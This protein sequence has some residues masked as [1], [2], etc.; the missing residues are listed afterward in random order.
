M[1]ALFREVNPIPVKYVA[2]LQGLCAPE[3][4]LPLCEPSPELARQ[5]KRLFPSPKDSDRGGELLD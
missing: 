2:S 5:L 1:Q 3:Y 4:R